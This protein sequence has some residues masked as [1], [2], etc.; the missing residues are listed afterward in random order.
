MIAHWT[1][2]DVETWMVQAERADP[3]IRNAGET[4]PLTWPDRHVTDPEARKAL[5]LWI[6]CEARGYAFFDL[7]TRRGIPYTT[8]LRRKNQ[9]VERIVMLLNL[10]ASLA[11][12][13]LVAEA[14][15]FSPVDS[16]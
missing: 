15:R 14:G 6:W 8:A 16:G 12:D 2:K 3:R 5:K 1:R 4:R 13:H 9:A 11:E 10:E 7:C